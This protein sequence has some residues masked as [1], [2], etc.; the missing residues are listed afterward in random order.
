LG[1]RIE[2]LNLPEVASNARVADKFRSNP[3]KL[4][5]RAHRKTNEHLASNRFWANLG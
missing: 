3:V 2:G 5:S 4:I 1:S